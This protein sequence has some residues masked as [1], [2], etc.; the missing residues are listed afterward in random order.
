MK[1][2]VKIVS[3]IIFLLFFILVA[4]NTIYGADGD[5]SLSITSVDI[6]APEPGIYSEGQEI[7]VTFTFS[8]P[9]KGTLPKYSIYFGNDISKN[10]ELDEVELTDFST[11]ATYKYTIKSGDNGE[12]KPGNFIEPYN[13]EIETEDGTKYTLGSPFMSSFEN[14]IYAATTIEWTN[15]DNAGVEMSLENQ[16][17]KSSFKLFI[18]NVELNEN[19]NYYIHLSHNPNEEIILKSPSDANNTEVWMGNINILNNQLFLYYYPL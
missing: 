14:K 2:K 16:E 15:F 1:F 7:N 5:E 3:I 4:G 10:I 11:E 6:T 8:Q 19:N 12:L 18:Q 9:I 13:Y 17:Y